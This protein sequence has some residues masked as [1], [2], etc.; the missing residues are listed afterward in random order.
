MMMEGRCL[1]SMLKDVLA[2]QVHVKLCP[3]FWFGFFKTMKLLLSVLR[4]FLSGEANLD[5]GL[6]GSSSQI[7]NDDIL[8][9]HG[10]LLRKI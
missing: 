5:T 4:D 8:V 2:W 7:F 1:T 6:V 3:L 9:P 10:S